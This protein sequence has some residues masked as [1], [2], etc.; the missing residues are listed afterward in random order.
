MPFVLD[1]D[2]VAVTILGLPV[3]WY[4]L[5]LVVA[6]G[7]A[8][9]LAQREARRR[10]IGPEIVWDGAL[11]VGV[12]ALIG[13]RAL[14]V[15]QNE[16]S[17]LA[18]HPAH[19]IMVWMGGLSFYGGLIGAIVALALFARRRGIP[20]LVALDLTAPGAAI[21]QAI[22]HIGCLVGGDSYG[23]PT[24]L[25]WAVI[26]RNPAAM[27]PQN[28]P[29]HPTQ[30]YE[31]I[32]LALLFVGLSLGRGRLTSLGAGVTASAY[33]LGLAVIRFWLF[34]LRDEASVLLGLK[35]AQWIGLGIGVAAVV[36]FLT[37]RRLAR[38]IPAISLQLEASQ[39]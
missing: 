13:G 1:I 8:I 4:G 6:A 7:I 22:G 14:Y 30:A 24:D 12:A 35:T 17:T 31:A 26:Y 11:W 9:W 2:P 10:G 34:F 19:V 27:A 32:L 16:L 3:R 36:L 21:G 28:V 33:L 38:A 20:L 5:I 37:A 39:P 18:D 23:I 29:L 15:I 25:P